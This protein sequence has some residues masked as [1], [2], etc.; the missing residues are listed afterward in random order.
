MRKIIGIIGLSAA[1]V[2]AS[3][4]AEVGTISFGI[5]TRI[6]NNVTMTAAGAIG[7][8]VDIRGQDNCGLML[9]MAG[10]EAGTGAVTVT[11]ARSPDNVNWETTPRFTFIAALNGTTAVVAYTNLPA[12]TIGAA[13][14][15]KVISIA[16]ADANATG[17]NASL[18]LVKKTI[19]AAS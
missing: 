12:A 4:M 7:A 9:K 16:N 2:A 8:A 15:L 13:G 5:G 18:T 6:T 19:K 3:A 11:L 1:L 14:Y 10:S 17:T